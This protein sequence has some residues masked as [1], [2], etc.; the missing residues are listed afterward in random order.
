M[1]KI[2]GSPMKDEQLLKESLRH[3]DNALCLIQ[4]MKSNQG[5]ILAQILM[6]VIKCGHKLMENKNSDIG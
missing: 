4:E 2:N 3:V 6:T 5:N 1:V